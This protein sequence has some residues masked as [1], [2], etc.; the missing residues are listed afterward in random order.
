MSFE[1]RH[2]GAILIGGDALA[3]AEVGVLVDEL[4]SPSEEGWDELTEYYFHRVPKFTT[5][6]LA[7]LYPRGAQRGTETFWITNARPVRQG[8]GLW[9]VEVTYKGW[10][11]AKPIKVRIGSAA[12]QQTAENV[13]ITDE[14]GDPIGTFAKV[15]IHQNTP[16]ISVTRLSED[17]END[18]MTALVGTAQYPPWEAIVDA[19]PNFWYSLDPYLY[20]YPNGWVLMGSDCDELPGTIPRVGLITDTYKFIQDVS[21]G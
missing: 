7:T 6:E 4:L 18:G 19:P 5:G 1:T 21:P 14:L 17:I 2:P 13:T 20:H 15:Q 11:A 16:T 9:I 3:D 8:P 12:E 10:D